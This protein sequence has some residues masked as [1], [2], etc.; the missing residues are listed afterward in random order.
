MIKRALLLPLLLASALPAQAQAPLIS[1]IKWYPLDA[2][3][4]FQ[5]ADAP[6]VTADPE[7]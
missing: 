1:T 2:Y 6:D 7:S 5:K 3:C 4:A